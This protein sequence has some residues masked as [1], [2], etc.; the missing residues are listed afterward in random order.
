MLSGFL[1]CVLCA[2]IGWNESSKSDKLWK[3]FVT[4]CLS[5]DWRRSCHSDTQ[6]EERINKERK[7]ERQGKSHR[8]VMSAG[9]SSLDQ[10]AMSDSSCSLFIAPLGR[11]LHRAQPKRHTDMNTNNMEAA[12]T[13]RVTCPD[14]INND[15]SS[16]L[17]ALVPGAVHWRCDDSY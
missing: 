3:C 5:S 7:R 6:W 12:S 16:H 13:H 11:C 14:C 10:L 4:P 1:N 9:L 8:L 17:N 15:D 2:Y